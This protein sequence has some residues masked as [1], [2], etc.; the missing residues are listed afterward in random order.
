V[1]ELSDLI[2]LSAHIHGD[3]ARGG[4]AGDLAEA[5]WRASAC[6]VGY[7]GGETH[8][9]AKAAARDGDPGAIDALV[10]VSE[11]IGFPSRSAQSP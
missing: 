10:G 3:G 7:G 5:L 2:S 9:A 6:A 1:R 8:E 4:D 11:A